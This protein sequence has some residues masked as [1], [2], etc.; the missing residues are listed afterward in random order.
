MEDLGISDLLQ[1]ASLAMQGLF[2]KAK[3]MAELDDGAPGAEGMDPL[4]SQSPR[5]VLRLLVL[6]HLLRGCS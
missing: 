2:G 1:H 5:L 3:A 4:Q 6:G